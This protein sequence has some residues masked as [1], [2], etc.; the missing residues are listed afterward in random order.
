MSGIV[1]LKGGVDF[2]EVASVE[3][4][5]DVEIEKLRVEIYVHV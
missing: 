1:V 4:I 2:S 5:F 3:W